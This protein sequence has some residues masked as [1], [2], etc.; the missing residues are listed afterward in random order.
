[1]YRKRSRKIF[2]RRRGG[3]FKKRTFRRRFRRSNKKMHRRH[4]RGGSKAMKFLKKMG[5]NNYV[6]LYNQFTESL[7]SGDEDKVSLGGMARTKA[8]PIQLY[9]ESAAENPN[10]TLAIIQKYNEC[11]IVGHSIKLTNVRTSWPGTSPSYVGTITLPAVSATASDPNYKLPI[12]YSNNG[13][14]PTYSDLHPFTTIST[15]G[16]SVGSLTGLIYN[17]FNSGSFDF[18]QRHTLGPDEIAMI[19]NR[20]ANDPIT[21]FNISLAPVASTQIGQTFGHV[22]IWSFM[23]KED[24]LKLNANVATGIAVAAPIVRQIGK[25]LRQGQSQSWYYK[26]PRG[27]TNPWVKVVY[28]S[29]ILGASTYA[30]GSLSAY[31]KGL[32]TA[33]NTISGVPN[34]TF[35][36]AS[37]NTYSY[38]YNDIESYGTTTSVTESGPGAFNFNT[39]P[40][41]VQLEYQ[42]KTYIQLRQVGPVVTG[43]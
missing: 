18:P 10:A 19:A 41:S 12:F 26:L 40:C 9:D 39:P 23:D 3:A 30:G 16:T 5:D 42:L 6:V 17:G 34:Y 1:M 7:N 28:L 13:P 36:S 4:R 25:K 20:T 14:A 15:G 43:G 33:T 21:V 38:V 37:M 29:Q 22:P 11:R 31:V 35:D 2:K 24:T 27:K 8:I 32:S